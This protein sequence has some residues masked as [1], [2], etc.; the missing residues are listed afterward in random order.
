MYQSKVLHDI[1]EAFSSGDSSLNSSKRHPGK[2]SHSCRVT[3]AN[4]ILRF[5]V[6]TELFSSELKC[7][8]QFI[9]RFLRQC[10]LTS[11]I[12]RVAKMKLTSHFR[13]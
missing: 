7:L 3:T 1:C 12:I 10:C 2:L 8:F 5:Y 11:R 9:V 4:L 13:T 6:E